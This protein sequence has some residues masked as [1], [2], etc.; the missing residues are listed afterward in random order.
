MEQLGKFMRDKNG[1]F[2][3][4]KEFLKRANAVG[5]KAV[6]S[7]ETRDVKPTSDE[8]GLVS[9]FGRFITSAEFSARVGDVVEDALADLEA[10]GFKPR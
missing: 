9:E 7:L 5:S 3:V 6:E 8:P 1:K 4:G 10:R 2:A